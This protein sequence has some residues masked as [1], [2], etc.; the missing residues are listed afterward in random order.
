MARN[1]DLELK[2][3]NCALGDLEAS[4]DEREERIHV[5]SN[6][7]LMRRKFRKHKAVLHR[8]RDRLLSRGAPREFVAPYDPR[9][10]LSVNCALQTSASSTRGNWRM[11][12]VYGTTKA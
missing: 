4:V 6:S 10:S 2:S 8:D 1:S 11:P 12:F 3:G 9:K 5:A 7:Q